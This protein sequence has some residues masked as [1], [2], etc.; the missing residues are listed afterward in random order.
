M[1]VGAGLRLICRV[2]LRAGL[3]SSTDGTAPCRI[4]SDGTATPRPFGPWI[5]KEDTVTTLQTRDE[6]P[7]LHESR[8]IDSHDAY[9]SVRVKT[10]SSAAA[11]DVAVSRA[12]ARR[13]IS[14]ARSR[15]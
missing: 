3:Q 13:G 5:G 7:S 4:D 10:P 8:R 11:L 2:C 6:T 14:G 15:P 1:V 12:W 9:G